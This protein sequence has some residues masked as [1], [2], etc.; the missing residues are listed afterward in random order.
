MNTFCASGEYFSA[1]DVRIENMR[2]N[3]SHTHTTNYDRLSNR[4]N[5]E[6]IA[7]HRYSPQK[8]DGSY[9]ALILTSVYTIPTSYICN[10]I[11]AGLNGLQVD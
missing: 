4:T 3:F 10:S 9:H 8:T 1:G 6:M 11:Y 2:S 5:L 7:T